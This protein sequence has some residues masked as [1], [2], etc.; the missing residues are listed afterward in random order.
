MHTTVW[1]ARAGQHVLVARH[2]AYLCSTEA[3]DLINML[4]GECGRHWNEIVNLYVGAN[5][6][7]NLL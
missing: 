1:V 2:D 6:I 5:F 3:Q 7:P 4:R